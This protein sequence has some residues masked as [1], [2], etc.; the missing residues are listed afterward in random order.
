M[1]VVSLRLFV[2]LRKYSAFLNDWGC[3]IISF[4]AVVNPLPDLTML[5]SDTVPLPVSIIGLIEACS[6]TPSISTEIGTSSLYP[7]PIWVTLIC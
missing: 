7:V 4:G 6:P 3:E 1:I 2:L 5:N